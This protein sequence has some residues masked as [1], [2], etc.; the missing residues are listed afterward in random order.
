MLILVLCD[1]W[2]VLLI[3]SLPSYFNTGSYVQG[4]C[5]IDGLYYWH[6]NPN[7]YREGMK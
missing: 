1:L 6:F 7:P 4:S 5:I 3:L 2:L